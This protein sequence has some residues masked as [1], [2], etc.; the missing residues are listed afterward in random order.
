MAGAKKVAKGRELGKFSSPCFG[1]SF[2]SS[3]LR[4]FSA[5]EFL[6]L[7]NFF[8][9]DSLSTKSRWQNDARLLGHEMTSFQSHWWSP[10]TWTGFWAHRKEQAERG[11]I[12]RIFMCENSQSERTGDLCPSLQKGETLKVL[13]RTSLR[14]AYWSL[15]TRIYPTSSRFNYWIQRNGKNL[16]YTTMQEHAP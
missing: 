15:N 13:P 4:S 10:V 14:P 8:H 2:H 6:L 11:G 7:K 12:W 16:C 5:Y 9:R 3:Y 1:G